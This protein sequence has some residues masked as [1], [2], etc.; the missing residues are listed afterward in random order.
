M[1]NNSSD[2]IMKLS[3]ENT[4]VSGSKVLDISKPLVMGILN[5]TPDSFYAGSRNNGIQELLDRANKHLSEGANILDIGAISTRPGAKDISEEKEIERLLSHLQI[6]RNTFPD[7]WISVDTWRSNV[8][9]ACLKEGADIIND[10]SGGTFDTKMLPL[11]AKNNTP[12]VMMHI[13]GEPHNMQLNPTYV[14]VVNEIYEFFEMQIQRFT[15]AGA[16]QI[17]LDPGYGF[18]KTLEHNYEIL[19]K[20]DTF[21]KLGYPLLSGASRKSM[22]H[23]LLD[24][25]ADE[26]LNGTTI[27]NTLSLMN[28]AKILRVHDVKEA[29]EII[30]VTQMYH[31]A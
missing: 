21:L 24:I 10:I 25:T 17:I 13:K 26:A 31:S 11:I 12:Y 22:I 16:T 1:P 2:N 15:K 5:L 18:G 9:K 3:T 29:M 19:K 28:G 7:C 23:K 6:L 4:L 20:S 14:D 8:A 30:K 27:I